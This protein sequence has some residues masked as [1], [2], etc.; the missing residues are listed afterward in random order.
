M[1]EKVTKKTVQVNQPTHALARYSCPYC[2]NTFDSFEAIKS[3]IIAKHKGGIAA[4]ARGD[5]PSHDQRP[6]IQIP[7]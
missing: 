4:R 2:L 5:H 3:H 7:G 1:S 6:E